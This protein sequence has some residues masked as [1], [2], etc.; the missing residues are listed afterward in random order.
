MCLLV[1]CFSDA[2]GIGIL[3]AFLFVR[4]H[5]TATSLEKRIFVSYNLSTI[6]RT[7]TSK[8]LWLCLVRGTCHVGTKPLLAQL[9]FFFLFFSFF[10][11]FLFFLC[12]KVLKLIKR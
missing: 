7:L 1:F 6:N 9:A 12:R 10:Y 4:F 2:I 11:F 5:A 8:Y 3:C